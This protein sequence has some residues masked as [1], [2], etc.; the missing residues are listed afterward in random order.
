LPVNAQN[1]LS[2]APYQYDA[3][4]NL[5][6][7][8]NHHYTYD[9]ENRVVLVESGST[10]TYVYDGPAIGSKNRRCSPFPTIYMTM[11]K[12]P[13]AGLTW[14]WTT[15][16]STL[17]ESVWRIISWPVNVVRVLQAAEWQELLMLHS[18]A[19]YREVANEAL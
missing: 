11:V 14:Q 8:G 2:G 6:Y 9:A 16:T 5:T 12:S 3:A 15:R 1:Q 13:R 7:D 10:A 17:Q 18:I 4:G 19:L